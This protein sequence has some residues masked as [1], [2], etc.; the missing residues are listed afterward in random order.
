MTT[1]FTSP[2]L[3]IHGVLAYAISVAPGFS[4]AHG[5]LAWLDSNPLSAVSLLQ[6]LETPLQIGEQAVEVTKL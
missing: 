4:Q 5:A 1:K 2:M 6:P 3:C